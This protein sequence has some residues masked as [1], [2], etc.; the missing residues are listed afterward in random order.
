MK[1]SWLSRSAIALGAIHFPVLFLRL[2]F[3]FHVQSLWP[4]V[5]LF[6]GPI[7]ATLAVVAGL[8]N[9]RLR[10]DAVAGLLLLAV[11]ALIYFTW[12]LAAGSPQLIFRP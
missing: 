4:E 11:Y 10:Y 8:L 9:R 2:T 7:L 3:L 5:L 12:W 6:S 1:L